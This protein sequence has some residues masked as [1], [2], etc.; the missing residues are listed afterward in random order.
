MTRE[1][2]IIKASQ[3]YPKHQQKVF[4]D[5]VLW[6]DRNP[7]NHWHDAQGD[8]LPPIDK[9]VIVLLDNG[10]VCFAH[11]PVESYTAMSIINHSEMEEYYPE[12]YDKGGWN[13]P[14]IKWWCDISLPKEGGEE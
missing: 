13:T 7:Q 12:R 4:V 1:K 11:R 10:K 2:Q 14:N 9:E 6:G 3:L 5:G 8:D